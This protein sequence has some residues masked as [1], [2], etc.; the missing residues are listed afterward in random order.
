[1]KIN[2]DKLSRIIMSRESMHTTDYL[3]E[4]YGAMTV[5]QR[6]EIKK[7]LTSNSLTKINK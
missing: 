6:E 3:V 7:L 2:K 4:L 1:M 5:E